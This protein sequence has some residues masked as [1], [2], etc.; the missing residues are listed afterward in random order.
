MRVVGAALP[1]LGFGYEKMREAMDEA[2]EEEALRLHHKIGHLALMASTAPMLGL[3]G[4]VTGMIIA[5]N[6]IEIGAREP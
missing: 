6:K 4:T 1:R 2:G 5:F 3:L